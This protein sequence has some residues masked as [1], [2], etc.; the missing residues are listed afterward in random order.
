MTRTLRIMSVVFSILALSGCYK[1]QYFFK[2]DKSGPKIPVK[3]VKIADTKTE[4]QPADTEAV[5]PVKTEPSA[6]DL[7][8]VPTADAAPALA[9]ADKNLDLHRQKIRPEIKKF[10]DASDDEQANMKP[11]IVGKLSE[12]YKPLDVSPP[13]HTKPGWRS[14]LLW[15]FTPD[16]DFK[17]S[18]KVWKAHAADNGKPFPSPVTRRKLLEFIQNQ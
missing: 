2:S 6:T 1:P 5:D 14:I 12:W 11:V 7:A 4:A 16:V 18:V 9:P 3:E 13:D 8:A 15:D 17:R 10:M